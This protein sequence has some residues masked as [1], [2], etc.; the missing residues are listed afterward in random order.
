MSTFLSGFSI[1]ESLSEE[2]SLSYSRRFIVFSSVGV[3]IV[4]AVTLALLYLTYRCLTSRSNTI[5]SAKLA[6]DPRS[7]TAEVDEITFSTSK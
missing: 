1:K 3:P 7:N 2:I 6:K 4:L 5:R